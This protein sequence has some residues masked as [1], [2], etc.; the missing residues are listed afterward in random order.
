MYYGFKK[1]TKEMGRL[2]IRPSM[3][4]EFFKGALQDGIWYVNLASF[5]EIMFFETCKFEMLHQF[6][7]FFMNRNRNLG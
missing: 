2:E 7:S 3:F 6:N 1:R 4:T 5:T